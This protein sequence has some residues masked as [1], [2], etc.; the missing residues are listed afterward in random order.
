M[1]SKAKHANPYF[2]YI[3]NHVHVSLAFISTR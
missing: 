3:H 2:H 1:R